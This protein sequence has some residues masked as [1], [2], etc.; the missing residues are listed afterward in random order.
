MYT[1]HNGGILGG[2]GVTTAPVT[3]E[4]GGFMAPGISPG[5]LTTGDLKLLLGST[6][7]IEINAL[8]AFDQ[9]LVRGTTP[10][11]G[12]TVDVTDATLEVL[13][14]YA[15]PDGSYYV[16]VDNDGDPAADPVTGT[17]LGL[18]EGA[19]IFPGEPYGFWITYHG[20]DGNDIALR[21]VP[22]PTTLTLL[23]LGGL[24]GLIRRRRR[25]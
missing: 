2:T 4:D 9:V 1:V 20:G 11:V 13:L 19:R 12:A 25:K 16:I 6:L 24:A 7:Q 14:G 8:D 18:P 22:E 5:E 15:P 17:F 23:G 3:V 10:V 21:A